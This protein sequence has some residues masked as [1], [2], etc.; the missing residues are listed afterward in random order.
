MHINSEHIA[1]CGLYCGVCGVLYATRDNN[2]DFMDR[3]LNVYKEQV[4]GLDDLT[5]DDLLCDG[6]MSN[7]KSVFCRVCSIKD[8]TQE[9]GF[10]GC[11]QCDEFPCKYVEQFPVPVGKRVILRVIPY[12]REHGTEKWIQDEENR[13]ICPECGHK[14]F[15]GAKRCNNCKTPVDLD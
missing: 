15:R 7:R 12:W 6:C 11:H 3:L 8:C 14:L 2:K 5:T 1:P 9:K 4:P 13:Y 10:E